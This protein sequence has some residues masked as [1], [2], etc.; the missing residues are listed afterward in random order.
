MSIVIVTDRNNSEECP[1]SSA[2]QGHARAPH[3][4]SFNAITCRVPLRCV[5]FSFPVFERWRLRWERWGVIGSLSNRATAGCLASRV[6]A[7]SSQMQCP[8]C[9]E[10]YCV[11]AHLW[12]SLKIFFSVEGTVGYFGIAYDHTITFTVCSILCTECKENHYYQNMQDTTCMETVSHNPSD[13][14][15]EPEAIQLIFNISFFGWTV[16]TCHISKVR[17]VY[18]HYN[19]IGG[20]GD[21]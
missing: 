16:N 21:I 9:S 15:N 5:F 4:I 7:C 17:Q 14:M 1:P 6:C 10:P 12:K 2:W 11:E 19:S 3:W 13:V 18:L 20:E 8:I